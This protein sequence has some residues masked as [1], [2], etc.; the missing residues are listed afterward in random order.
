MQTDSPKLAQIILLLGT[1][2]KIEFLLDEDFGSFSGHEG[3]YLIDHDD[4]ILDDFG[5][6]DS[7]PTRPPR[8]VRPSRHEFSRPPHPSSFNRNHYTGYS[9]SYSPASVNH[10]SM[11]RKKNFKKN[12]TGRKKIFIDR[13]RISLPFLN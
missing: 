1:H 10:P 13:N 3:N 7:F 4:Y 9:N 8:P 6:S 12:D 11:F 5:P 2:I